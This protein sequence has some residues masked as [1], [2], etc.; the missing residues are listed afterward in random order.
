[1]LGAGRSKQEGYPFPSGGPFCPVSRS[2]KVYPSIDPL[3]Q[4][5]CGGADT[6][7]Y[8]LRVIPSCQLGQCVRPLV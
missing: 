1:M 4:R 6:A 3:K 8:Q 5:R 2:V 7:H